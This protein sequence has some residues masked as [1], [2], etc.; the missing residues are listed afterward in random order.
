MVDKRA[1]QEVQGRDIWVKVNLR[2]IYRKLWVLREH[3]R[4]IFVCEG[5]RGVKEGR[6]PRVEEQEEGGGVRKVEGKKSPVEITSRIR[7]RA[8]VVRGEQK[9]IKK[10]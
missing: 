2:K 3:S 10:G 9:M 7:Q 4:G 1:A 8:E 5:C 6:G